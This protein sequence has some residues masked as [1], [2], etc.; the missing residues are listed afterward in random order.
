MAQTLMLSINGIDQLG[1]SKTLFNALPAGLDVLDIEQVV[2]DGFLQLGVVLRVADDEDVLRVTDL[3]RAALGPLGMTVTST[4]HAHHVSQQAGIRHRVSVL[5]NPLRTEAVASFT[6]AIRSAGGN[7]E[8]VELVANEP[9]TAL[10]F[11]IFGADLNSL[12]SKAGDFARRFGADIAIQELNLDRRGR[13]LVVMDVDSTV[14]QNEVIEL[15]AARAGV[16]AEVK[17][18]TDAAMAGELDFEQS[19]RA[20]VKL[21]KG[22]PDSV[23]AEVYQQVILTPGAKRLCDVLNHLGYEIALVSG[24][25]TEVV[26]EIARDLGVT[27]FRAN[28]LEVVDG[29]LTGELKG[30]IVDRAAKAEYL[31]DFAKEFGIPLAR[32]I[33]IGDGANDLDM[34]EVA[35]LGVAFNAKPIVQRNA[36]AAINL[37]Y[38]DTALYLMGITKSEIDSA[39]VNLENS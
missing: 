36:D 22:L 23:F 10:Q 37:P 38:L 12:K 21:L 31:Q 28:E 19:L 1:V 26:R 15:I 33:A 25:F 32:T 16:E 3:A 27:N 2:A 7:I 13:Q 34:M 14:I 30:K 18:I 6:E 24:G 4:S 39:A 29:Q 11:K 8:R 20:R 5:G 35:G 17:R 9:V